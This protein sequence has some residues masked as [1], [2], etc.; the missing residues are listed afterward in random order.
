MRKQ[1]AI[2]ELNED[3]LVPGQ[4]V[5]FETI[6]RVNRAREKKQVGDIDVVELIQVAENTEKPRTRRSR[7]D[8]A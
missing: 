1:G 5:D 2:M 3:G 4:A 7:K 8:A 6:M